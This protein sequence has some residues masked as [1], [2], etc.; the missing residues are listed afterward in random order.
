M[1]L[2]FVVFALAACREKPTIVGAW[3]VSNCRECLVACGGKVSGLALD[4]PNYGPSELEMKHEEC[5]LLCP[6]KKSFYHAGTVIAGSPADN[7]K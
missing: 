6:G 3:R 7:C 4:G 2:A 5:A 1:R